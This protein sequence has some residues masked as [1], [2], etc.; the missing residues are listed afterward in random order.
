MDLGRTDCIVLSHGHIDHTWGLEPLI[1]HLGKEKTEK[2]EIVAHPFVFDRKLYPGEG[3]IG[4]RK[5]APEV[6]EYFDLKLSDRPVWLTDRLC[7]LG[8]IPRQNHFEAQ[9]S[10]GTVI[11]DG[12]EIPDFVP[13]DTALAYKGSGGLVII[14]GCSHAGICNI[15]A[16]AREECQED[17]ILDIIGG[18]HL[19]D[20]DP[21]LMEETCGYLQSCAPQTTHPCH[22]TDLKARFELSKAVPSKNWEADPCSS[23]HKW[24]GSASHLTVISGPV[25]HQRP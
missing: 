6:R 23:S 22:C 15:V 7:Y 25:D 5:R 10:I 3:D 1:D 2:I 13:D 24:Q 11:R 4:S 14:A 12:E 8:E 9:E 17:R 18:F 19:L 16:Y 20:A 21:R